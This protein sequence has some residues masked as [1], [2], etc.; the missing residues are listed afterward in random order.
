MPALKGMCPYHFV[1]QGSLVEDHF[2]RCPHMSPLAGIGDY[3]A[4]KASFQFEKFCYCYSCGMPQDRNR[5]GEGPRCLVGHAFS[6]KK[7]CEFEHFIFR[8]AFC[9]WQLPNLRMQMI[10]GLGARGSMDTQ[11]GFTKWAVTEEEDEG[12]YHNCLEAF[13]W[14]CQ[15]KEMEDPRFFC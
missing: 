9:I 4:F 3:S 12:K 2:P 8:V 13:L 6:K 11:E 10:A 7:G 1:V 14:F 5:N 15:R